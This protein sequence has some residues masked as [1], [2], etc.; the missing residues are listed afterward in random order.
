MRYSLKVKIVAA[1]TGLTLLA[2][3]TAGFL[4]L[5]L[6]VAGGRWYPLAGIVIGVSLIAPFIIIDIARRL[7]QPLT[8]MTVELEKGTDSKHLVR[9]ASGE[10]ELERLAAAFNRTVA[11][12]EGKIAGLE[13]E[14]QRH[15]AIVRNM[16]SG[17]ILVNR[18]GRI[19]L[20]NPAAAQMLAV[21]ADNVIGAH[22]L[23]VARDY[24]LS[25]KIQTALATGETQTYDLHPVLPQ[26]KVIEVSLVPLADGSGETATVLLVL[27]D[28]TESHH[29]AKMRAEF[30]SNVSHEMRTP[31]TS[32]KGFTETLLDGSL[33]DQ[34]TARRFIG[35]IDSEAERLSRL[36][37]DL[38]DLSKIESGRIRLDFRKT[39]LRKVI[40][41]TA[42]KLQPQME[43]CGLQLEL[44]VSLDLPLIMADA[45]R[46]AQVLINLADNSSKFTPH[47]GKITI[48]AGERD[49][50]VCVSV[51]DNGIG[52]PESD[53]PR[54]F[55]RF[56]RVD[57]ART[58]TTGGT[59]LGLAIVKHIVE[60]HGGCVSVASAVGRGSTFTFC[61][62]KE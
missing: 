15:T 39:N 60:A 2:V 10:A 13:E 34:A 48:S 51:A 41:E 22:N 44:A 50:M 23:E 42:E 37:D 54:I 36:I 24:N 53:L 26:E 57:K 27:R 16:R 55:E 38:L 62:P 35:V 40:T 31:L 7:L 5:Q 4:L 18:T 19:V 46:L 58:R 3:L 8:Q 21:E 47:G 29:L 59:G 28:T 20:L 6:N 12:L 9:A 52:I 43:K 11:Q 45:D 25:Q 14:E 17:I 49:D 61:L 1:Y 56:Y 32:I 30:V 33:D